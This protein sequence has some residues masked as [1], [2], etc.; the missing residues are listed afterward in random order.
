MGCWSR[1]K[2]RSSKCRKTRPEFDYQIAGSYHCWVEPATSAKT[3]PFG[4]SS[5]EDSNKSR[6]SRYYKD[7]GP[8]LLKCRRRWDGQGG[9]TGIGSESQW[10]SWSEGPHLS[11]ETESKPRFMETESKPRKINSCSAEN[12]SNQ[13]CFSKY[14]TQ[15][16]MK[17]LQ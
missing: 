2:V 15:K 11:V 10:A 17:R 7:T 13:N 9:V 6:P 12:L 5:T 8:S 14:I 4:Q 1:T 16:T 3:K